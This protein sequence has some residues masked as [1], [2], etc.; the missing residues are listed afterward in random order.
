MLLHGRWTTFVVYLSGRRL[1]C[2][3]YITKAV[4]EILQSTGTSSSFKRRVH[5]HSGHSSVMGN[6]IVAWHES[7][8]ELVNEFCASRRKGV[9]RDG[10]AT[11]EWGTSE[12][13]LNMGV[14]ALLPLNGEDH[15]LICE[16]DHP[17]RRWEAKAR[18]HGGNLLC[19]Q[20]FDLTSSINRMMMQWYRWSTHEIIILVGRA[21][22][23]LGWMKSF[24]VVVQ[25]F[26]RWKDSAAPDTKYLIVAG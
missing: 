7:W 6:C 8:W 14:S 5:L 12:G 16:L 10:P 20:Y 4:H 23:R 26:L 11:G 2:C 13:G 22:R 1:Y 21:T 18:W 24:L 3:W 15:L 25:I 17:G 9:S 19:S